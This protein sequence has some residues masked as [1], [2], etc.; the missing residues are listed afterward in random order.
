VA[1]SDRVQFVLETGQGWFARHH[2]NTGMLIRTERGT[3]A[4]TFLRGR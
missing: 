4:G 3:L 1:S 2:V